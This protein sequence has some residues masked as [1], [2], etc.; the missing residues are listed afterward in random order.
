MLPRQHVPLPDADQLLQHGLQTSPE[1]GQAVFHLRGNGR[2]N[3]AR[4][5]AVGFQLP[6][7]R[8]QHMPGYAGQQPLQ[9]A[10]PLRSPQQLVDD[11]GLPFPLIMWSAASAGQP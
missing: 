3:G 4:H 8:R 2:I 9:L 1:I 10:E 6:E 11:P 7:L 5:N